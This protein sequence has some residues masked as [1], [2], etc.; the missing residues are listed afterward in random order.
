M[1]APEITDRGTLSGA[2]LGEQV[3]VYY[4]GNTFALVIAFLIVPTLLAVGLRGALPDARLGSWLL[5]MYL[6]AAGRSVLN[7]AYRRHPVPVVEARRWARAAVAGTVVSG[8]AWGAGG[9]LLFVPGVVHDQLL[10][11]LVLASVS[12]GAVVAL[13][14]L[15]PAFYTYILTSLFPVAVVLA[16]QGDRFHTVLALLVLVYGGALSYFA[17]IIH[18]ILRESL[19][20]RFEHVALLKEMMLKKEEAERAN[21]GKSRFL[22]AASHDLRQ[23]LHALGLFVAALEARVQATSA[24]VLI[25]HIR[26]SLQ[27]LED[28]LNSLLDISRLDAGVIVPRVFDSP[29]QPLFDRLEVEFGPQAEAKSL[30]LRVHPTD[31]AVATDPVL[32]ERIV[33]NL[34][35]NALR[36]TD[37]GGVVLGTRRR[38]E[39]IRVEVWDTGVGIAPEHQR[40]IFEEFF[41]V[42]NDAR[43]RN[44][45]LGLGL[46]IVQRLTHLLGHRLD[47]VSRPGRGSRFSVE[48]PW[49]ST[50]QA[51]LSAP[52]LL[53]MGFQGA[54]IGVIDDDPEVLSGMGALLTQWGCRVVAAART[55]QLLLML[56]GKPPMVII[57]DYRLPDGVTGVDAVAQVRTHY[58]IDVPAVIITG[59]TAVKR[60]QNVEASGIEILHKPVA[61][62]R[63]RAL[64]QR[65]SSMRSGL[66]PVKAHSNRHSD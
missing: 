56:R 8:M 65:L 18:R 35:S 58:G 19:Q 33:R 21:L 53:S 6:V 61:P 40:D 59:D 3:R 52:V 54:L 45:G 13:S 2:I 64:L 22:A 11:L 42:G 32:F 37:S 51:P 63:L 31:A 34:L 49:R 36:Y 43:D 25:K 48:L 27:A 41:Q 47:L 15:L 4:Q 16:R 12:A 28:L 24:R 50:P 9:V 23:P 29:L 46:A 14:A 10:L 30:S 44:K 66:P 20:L 57:V 62:A 7:I 1:K 55:E 39:L 17:S 38:R 5:A 26:S 60:L